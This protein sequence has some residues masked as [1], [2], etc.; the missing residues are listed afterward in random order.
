M[1]EDQRITKNNKGISLIELIIVLAIMSIIAGA[2]FLS[3]AVATDK[4][5]S[6]CA[7]K[8]ASSLE[9]T[10]SLALGKQSGWIEISK[11]S[12][13][14][15][16]IQMYVDGKAYGDRVSIGHSGLTVEITEEGTPS[17]TVYNLN[18]H[19]V[20]IRFSRSNGSITSSPAVTQIKVTNGRRTVV[21]KLD[22]FTGR[23]SVE[24]VV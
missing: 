10:R 23:V 8:I 6:S 3:T 1:K 15:V 22:K 7:E 14:Y 16:Y 24:K 4:H 13:E 17:P 20:T 11:V 18:D 9:Q 19:T 12:G 2:F 21:V 5:V